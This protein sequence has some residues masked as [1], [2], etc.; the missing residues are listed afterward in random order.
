MDTFMESPAAGRQIGTLGSL[1]DKSLADY[2]L[3]RVYHAETLGFLRGRRRAVMNSDRHPQV[4]VYTLSA[5]LADHVVRQCNLK[6]FRSYT[7]R[8]TIALVNVSRGTV[9]SLNDIAT[10][11]KEWDRSEEPLLD[12]ETFKFLMAEAGFSWEQ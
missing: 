3:K 2:Q 4:V 12:A 6:R 10:V 8:S 7:I 9:M 1:V 5:T 11:E